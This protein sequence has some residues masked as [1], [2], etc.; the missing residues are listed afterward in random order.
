MMKLHRREFLAGALAGVGGMLV[1]QRANAAELKS[2]KPFDP[3]EKVQLGKTE[4]K[5]TKVGLGTGAGGYNQQSN[6]TRLGQEKFTAL[7][8]GCLDRGMNWFDAAD[9]Y[10]SHPFLKAALEGVPRDQYLL[11]SKIWYGQG[12]IPTPMDQR[13]EADIMVENFLKQLGTDHIDLVLLHCLTDPEWN[14]KYE[15]HMKAMSESKEKG[16]IRAHGVSCHSLGAFKTA[17]EE[18]WVESIHER[19]NPYRAS[20]DGT[21]EEV[22][23]LFQKAHDNGKGT[24]G[25]K[26][27][28]NGQFR[29]SDLQRDHS[30]EFV[31]NLPTVDVMTIGFEKMEEVD[32]FEA[33][34]KKA[35]RRPID[36]PA[37]PS[38]ASA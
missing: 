5:M 6:Q 14:T 17:A 21:P 33:R 25:M 37:A 7:V 26:I 12:G 9:L 24:V 11:V 35:V 27:I 2:P 29:N 16:K 22:L 32:D 15:S 34:V 8:R 28:G 3:Y 19:I 1:G 4:L 36:S 18:P 23:P 38:Q 20:M 31:F 30:I 10:G 13:P